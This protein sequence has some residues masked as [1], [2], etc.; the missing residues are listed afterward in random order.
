MIALQF[1]FRVLLAEKKTLSTLVEPDEE[2][3][4]L[5]W[6][7]CL[8]SSWPQAAG[9][10]KKL[11]LQGYTGFCS[12]VVSPGALEVWRQCWRLRHWKYVIYHDIFPECL[13]LTNTLPPHLRHPQLSW[14]SVALGK[15]GP[16]SCYVFNKAQVSNTWMVET[17]KGCFWVSILILVT[18]PL[19]QGVLS[20][21]SFTIGHLRG[22]ALSRC[23]KYKRVM[24]IAVNTLSL[25]GSHDNQAGWR[26]QAQP[27]WNAYVW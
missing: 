1:L 20:P 15:I 14:V 21:R 18:F 23:W 12:S 9:A 4:D 6:P 22:Q 25:E 26:E 24:E 11:P 10:P 19:G 16:L 13:A 5:T 7:T 3:C 2:S 27:G 17:T 8:G